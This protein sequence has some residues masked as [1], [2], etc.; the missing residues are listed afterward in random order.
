MPPS[1]QADTKTLYHSTRV[2]WYVF[3]VLEALLAFRFFLKLLGAN[4]GAG[5]TDFI[6]TLSSIPLAPFRFVFGTNAVGSSVFEWS[7]LLAA[8][9]YWVI[10]WGIVKLVL[11]TRPVNPHR[12]EARLEEQDSA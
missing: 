8:L 9:V 4:P 5:F 1:A 6:Y 12:A 2:I 11:M 10:F 7:T 3:Y